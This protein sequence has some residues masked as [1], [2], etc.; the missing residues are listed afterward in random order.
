MNRHLILLSFCTIFSGHARTEPVNSAP[1]EI[2][3]ILYIDSAQGLRQSV[4]RAKRDNANELAWYPNDSVLNADAL[5]LPTATFNV[6]RKTA[7]VTVLHE[8]HRNGDLIS[9][10]A[11]L[12]RFKGRRMRED[13]LVLANRDDPLGRP[14][15]FADWE[16]DSERHYLPAPCTQRDH[17]R[18]SRPSDY[19]STDGSVGCHEWTAQLYRKERPYIDISTYAD[20]RSFIGKLMGWARFEDAPKPVIGLQGKTWLCLHECPA[21]E[22][23]GVIPD[24]KVWARKHAYPIP[25]APAEQPE[26]PYS[27]TED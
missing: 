6:G 22:K 14:F 24:I 7:I 25:V 27:E 9:Q 5:L 26:Y 13:L 3:Y 16:T 20:G 23:P 18:Y 8:F 15:Y 1:W 12:S 17:S 10:D 4:A 19:G 21:G 11:L 2:R